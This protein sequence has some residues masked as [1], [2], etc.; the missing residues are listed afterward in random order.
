MI[1]AQDCL[2]DP[3]LSL[4]LPGGLRQP[5]GWTVEL[6]LLAENDPD[7]PGELIGDR[8]TNRID[9]L[10]RQALNDPALKLFPGGHRVFWQHGRQRPVHHGSE[11][12]AG[13]C[14]LASI[15]PL[16]ALWTRWNVDAEPTQARLAGLGRF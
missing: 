3:S 2:G 13:S 5:A 7:D 4:Q 16:S 12:A 6:L 10:H 9:L 15:F 11:Y 14:R 1:S 8:D